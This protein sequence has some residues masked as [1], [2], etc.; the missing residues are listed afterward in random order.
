MPTQWLCEKFPYA[1]GGALAPPVHVRSVAAA[2]VD[3]ATMP[4]Y[5]G[6]LTVLENDKLLKFSGTA[7]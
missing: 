1:L 3:A 7:A 4:E 2:A 5:G 6:K